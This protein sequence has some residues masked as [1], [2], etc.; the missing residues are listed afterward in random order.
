MPELDNFLQVIVE[1]DPE[2][3]EV[4]DPVSD[5]SVLSLSLSFSFR[6]CSF[7]ALGLGGGL[8]ASSDSVLSVLNLLSFLSPLS[9]L[10]RVPGSRGS[11]SK[12]LVKPSPTRGLWLK[13][14]A[15]SVGDG[16]ARVSPVAVRTTPFMAE[17]R[18]S[19]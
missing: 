19:V 4:E 3:E 15:S 9:P 16:V 8:S 14:F 17:G 1:E 18:V 7:L 10:L 12:I 13:S 2:P 5:N 11:D 6:S